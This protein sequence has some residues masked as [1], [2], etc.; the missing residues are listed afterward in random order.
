MGVGLDNIPSVT[1]FVI[2]KCSGFLLP[3][4]LCEASVDIAK[5]FTL[6]VR[7]RCLPKDVYFCYV[8][9]ALAMTSSQAKPFAG[10]R[11]T[12]QPVPPGDLRELLSSQQFAFDLF[13]PCVIIVTSLFYGGR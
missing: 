8:A 7:E 9:T 2:V 6:H 10:A 3:L 11:T 12:F 1:C 4:Y 5:N 13:L